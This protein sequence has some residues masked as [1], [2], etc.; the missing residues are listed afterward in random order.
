MNRI[1]IGVIPAAGQ[2]M[3]MEYLRH[4]L[5]KCLMPLYDRPIIHHVLENMR[6]VGVEHVYIIV[7]YKRDMV[8]EYLKS[9]EGELGIGVEF[10]V[11]PRL[12]GVADAI[13]LVRDLVT[14][15]FIV[16]L[17]DDFTMTRSLCGMIDTFF[18]ND[19]IAVEGV[20]REA[21][22]AVLRLTCCLELDYDHRI[23]RIA[24]KPQEPFSM[25]RG[26]GLYVFGCDIFRYIEK[27]PVSELRGQ[28]DITE[29]IA[30]V[31]DE[32]RA[33]GAFI[34]GINININSYEDL[35]WASIASRTFKREFVKA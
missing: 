7:N 3:R 5:P 4:I 19:A 24:E 30:Q 34:D 15:P 32:G 13:M 17:G 12:S 9:V 26:C 29:A 6:T 35:L 11:Q 21:D 25:L 22:D 23:L 18:G 14:E 20:V 27:T 10:I 31:V 8:V 2:G 16:I 1:K 28:R 33:Y